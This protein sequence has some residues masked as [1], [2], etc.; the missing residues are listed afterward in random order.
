MVHYKTHSSDW[1]SHVAVVKADKH[2]ERVT[3][4]SILMCKFLRCL[5]GINTLQLDQ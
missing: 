4:H 2:L 5:A 3:A 1:M